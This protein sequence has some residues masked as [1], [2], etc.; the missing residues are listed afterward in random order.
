MNFVGRAKRLDD[1]D[2]PAIGALIGVG[3]DEIHAFLDVEAAGSGFDKF[4][5]PKMLFEP[6][7]FYRLLPPPPHC[8][9]SL[10]Q[11]RPCQSGSGLWAGY[12]HAGWNPATT[13]R[14]KS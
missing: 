7:V 2:I 1:L 9:Q 10:Q 14:T 3:E 6:H 4:S 11:P 8:L 5:R 13:E 12:H